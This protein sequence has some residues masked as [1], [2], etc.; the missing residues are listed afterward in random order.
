MDAPEVESFNS[1]L[2]EAKLLVDIFC[3]TTCIVLNSLVT[4]DGTLFPML[5]EMNP[6]LH[7]GFLVGCVEHGEVVAAARQLDH[8]AQEQTKQL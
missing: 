1:R 7:A 2:A 8:A 3:R 4:C 5:S 6:Q